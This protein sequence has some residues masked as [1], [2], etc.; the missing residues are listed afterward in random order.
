MYKTI[1][2]NED[3]AK[4]ILEV[5]RHR[6]SIDKHV[7]RSNDN[8]YLLRCPELSRFY[9]LINDS[10]SL[11]INKMENL[12]DS[13][14]GKTTT[15]YPLKKITDTLDLFIKQDQKQINGRPIPESN[16][17]SETS[18]SQQSEEKNS[19]WERLKSIKIKIFKK[20]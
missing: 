18:I 14:W 15:C 17:K 10:D 13:L 5:K 9:A 3:L 12:Q 6:D 7:F 8:I 1:K 2:K 4:R 11:L 19:F 16:I 20:R